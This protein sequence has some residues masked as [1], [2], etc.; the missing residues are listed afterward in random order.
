MNGQFGGRARVRHSEHVLM[1]Q[2]VRRRYLP[3]LTRRRQK[4]E[5]IVN[6]VPR[7]P[8]DEQCRILSVNDS[9]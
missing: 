3:D 8:I 1:L 2:F 6:E 5:I 9:L 7:H 4:I